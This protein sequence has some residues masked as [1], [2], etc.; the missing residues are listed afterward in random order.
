MDIRIL[1][2][3]KKYGDR[4]IF[5]NFSLS[6]G[7]G[8]V[9]A[10]MGKSGLGK[11]TLMRILMGLEKYD[12]GEIEGLEGIRIGAV[13]QEDRLCENLSAIT[14]V[15]MVCKKGTVTKKIKKELESI[16]LKGNAVK[17]VKELSGGM[18]RRVAIVRSIMAEPDIIVFDEPFKGLDIE[19]RKEVISYL[20][21]KLENRTVI[22]VT[23]DIEEARALNA[24]IINI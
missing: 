16:G 13:F 15:S 1:N 11:T 17:P 2:L 12:S 3:T 24:E 6:I 9:T 5:R 4:D 21:K 7:K 20:R 14:N 8:K 10:L 23:H 22:I 18:K 19:T